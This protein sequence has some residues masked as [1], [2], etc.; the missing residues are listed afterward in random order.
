MI[1]VQYQFRDGEL[2]RFDSHRM[3]YVFAYRSPHARTE[4]EAV[5]QYEKIFRSEWLDRPSGQDDNPATA[6]QGK[7][8]AK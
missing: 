6:N 5:R 1:A 8:N 3:E 2:Y 4:A 7:K